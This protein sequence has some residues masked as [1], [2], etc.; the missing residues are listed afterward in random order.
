MPAIKPRKRRRRQAQ[1]AAMNYLPFFAPPL[2]FVALGCELGCEPDCGTTGL[3]AVNGRFGE[4][5]V[6]VYSALCCRAKRWPVFDVLFTLD[7]LLFSLPICFDYFPVFLGGGGGVRGRGVNGFLDACSVPCTDFDLRGLTALME[8]LFGLLIFLSLSIKLLYFWLRHGG[9]WRR[10]ALFPSVR[11]FSFASLFASRFWRGQVVH[12]SH[13]VND[14]A[15]RGEKQKTY[16][17]HLVRF[18]CRKM[19]FA[20]FFGTAEKIPLATYTESIIY[21][22]AKN[23]PFI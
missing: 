9:G 12:L 10:F 14:S 11:G 3:G 16:G 19:R 13:C 18:F 22:R 7:I 23:A 21:V 17:R 2:W 1:K 6:L 5:S 8:S 4:C 15:T 20:P